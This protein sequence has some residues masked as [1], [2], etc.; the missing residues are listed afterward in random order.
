[1]CW[2]THQVVIHQSSRDINE[3]VTFSMATPTTAGRDVGSKDWSIVDCGT[4]CGTFSGYISCFIEPTGLPTGQN[5]LVVDGVWL[6]DGCHA[7]VES[8]TIDDSQDESKKSNLMVP[9]L[10]QGKGMSNDGAVAD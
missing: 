8:A 10:K 9:F 1:M 7:V 6:E 2:T 3:W 5:R 4:G